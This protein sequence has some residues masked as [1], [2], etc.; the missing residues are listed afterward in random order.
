MRLRLLSLCSVFALAVSSS[1]CMDVLVNMPSKDVLEKR[2]QEKGFGRF[3]E[4]TGIIQKL[5]NRE[6]AAGGVVNAVVL[7][8][9]DYDEIL[10]KDQSCPIAQ[11]ISATMRM[12]EPQLLEALLKD[13]PDALR[14]ANEFYEKVKERASK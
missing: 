4:D 3:M 8:L 6:L 5:A 12:C 2:L 10:K 1:Y 14:A 13:A 7:A 9:C 11:K